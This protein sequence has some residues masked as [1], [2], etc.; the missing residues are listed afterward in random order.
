M[1]ALASNMAA[2]APV[3]R[4]LLVLTVV[5]FVFW[6]SANATNHQGQLSCGKKPLIVFSGYIR[7][8]VPKVN[9]EVAFCSGF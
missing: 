2:Q 8:H 6:A 4:S 9:C 5:P 7:S 3:D 1:L